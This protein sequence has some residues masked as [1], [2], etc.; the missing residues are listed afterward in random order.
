MAAIN[1]QV[2]EPEPPS[3][4]DSALDWRRLYAFGWPAGSVRALMALIVFGTIW[5][6]LLLRPNQE[7]PEY[8][9][10]LLFII[11]GHYFAVRARAGATPEIGPG[12]LYLPRG[13]V[14]LLLIGGFVVSAALLYRQD[15]L[16]KIETN[17]AVVSLVLVFGFLLG[18][19][20]QHVASRLGGHGRQL[21]RILEDA[22]AIV[23]LAATLF[24][25]F[26]VWDAFFPG[27]P[28]SGLA[29]R[30]I[31]LGKIGLPHV[32][33]AVVGFYFGSRS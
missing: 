27:A 17:P 19:V 16:L 25:A 24:L 30:S 11:L 28:H 7:V 5:G 13:S 8:L 9:K 26:L 18:V 20:V 10:D 15:R 12:P 2:Q 1:P 32:T 33:A 3:T 31:G 21:P 23:S 6:F 4:P 22:R 29:D 14:R